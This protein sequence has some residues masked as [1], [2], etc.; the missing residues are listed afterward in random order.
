MKLNWEVSFV[1]GVWVCK[2]FG[3]EFRGETAVKAV[4]SAQAHLDE[5]NRTRKR[6]EGVQARFLV[7]LNAEKCSQCNIDS[8]DGLCKKHIQMYEQADRIDGDTAQRTD[9]LKHAPLCPANNWAGT[10]GVMGKC[11]CGANE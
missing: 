5:E 11:N 7:R 3:K 1:D 10:R 9:K 6:Y 8:Q 2:A 4:V